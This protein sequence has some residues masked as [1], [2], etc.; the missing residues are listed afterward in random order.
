M[1]I[2]W[3][4]LVKKQVKYRKIDETT[5]QKDGY[6]SVPVWSVKWPGHLTLDTGTL[7]PS[8]VIWFKRLFIAVSKIYYWHNYIVKAWRSIQLYEACH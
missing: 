8:A 3:M 6:A 4:Q 7:S 5:Y 2:D 1:K